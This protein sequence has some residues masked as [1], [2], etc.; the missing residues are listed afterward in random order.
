M[1]VFLNPGHDRE[2]DSGAVNPIHGLREADVVWDITES[3]TNCIRERLES[4][5]VETYTLQSD[6]L[7]YV[8]SEANAW[9]ADYFIS[10]HCNAFNSIAKG[11]EVEIYSYSSSG[12][13]LADA[14]QASLVSTM[15]T[16]DRGVR[17][18]PGLHV[19][20]ATD[21]PAILI[22]LAFIDNE[23]D[24]QLLVNRQGDFAAAVANGILGY[25]GLGTTEVDMSNHNRL[26]PNGKP[27]EQN[28]IDYLI[29]QGYSLTSALSFLD[30]TDKYSNSNMQT[31]AKWADSRVNSIGYGNNG[32][33]EFVRQFL[34]HANHWMGTLMTDGSQGNLM[35]VPNIMDYAKANGLWKEASEGGSLGD[36]CL[37]ETNYC[38]ADGP[39]HVVIA[40]GD[41][42]YWGNSSSRNKIIRS[43]IADDFG[44]ENIWGYV[45]TGTSG[46]G[47]V[48]QGESTRSASEIVGDA[49]STSYVNLAPNG[50]VYEQNDILYLTNQGYTTEQ[51]IDILSKSTKY[52]K[53]RVIAPNGKPYE[54]NDIDY[55]IKQGYSEEAAIAFLA[56]ADK[57]MKK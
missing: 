29:S 16:I 18:R 32:C 44:S 10:I 45:A 35:W 8:T 46:D 2:L 41:G 57:Y 14:V 34:L 38:K 52:T 25:V 30:T 26:A 39:D 56:T 53:T 17:E 4:A 28:D 15:G 24:Y 20:K 55:L 54:Q 22:E 3:I 42:E 12:K 37:L 7:G 40:T 19:L 1:K 50:S 33:T 31:A 43:S 9:E 49:G 36:I 21:M 11:T 51:A 13:P 6:S 47:F 27:Y 48:P 23:E 5:G